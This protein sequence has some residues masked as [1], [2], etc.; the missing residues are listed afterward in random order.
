MT[1]I[2]IS[3]YYGFGNAGDEAMLAALL[4]SILEIIPEAD[5][6]VITGNEKLTK[7]NHGV[8]T[9]HRLNFLGIT[10]AISHSHILISGGG[11]LLQDVT[12]SRSLYYYLAIIKI[13]L[14]LH[15][16]VMLYAQGI[17]PLRRRK[18]REAVRKVLERVDMIGVRDEESKK[19]LIS[20]GVLTPPIEVTADAVLSANPVDKKLGFLLLKKYAITGIRPKIGIAIRNWKNLS[21]YKI[22]VAKAADVLQ[23]RYNANIVFVPMQFPDDIRAA[24]DVCGFM[25]RE[26]IILKEQ[27]TTVELMSII[28]CMDV[29]LGIR[30][31]ALI[32]AS[33]MHVPVTAI[34]YDPKINNFID[35]IG[36]RLCGTIETVTADML[37]V[38]L[39]KKL[40]MG[41]LAP[42][43]LIRINQLRE[44]S[45]RNAYLALK[46][47]EKYSNS[48]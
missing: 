21:H 22:E 47:I 30:L 5:I 13:A 23:E 44:L 20:I 33:I 12:S 4:D 1:K 42:S 18:A 2:V 39:D 9:V 45:L 40:T 15:K 10:A 16:P 34:S 14:L 26:A 46:V 38:D 3:G 41:Q 32:F 17:G 36:E 19:E 48:L 37:I 7:A 8:K 25:K 28:G 35:L 11:S 29:L 31:H 6:T 27:Y 43:V 24:E